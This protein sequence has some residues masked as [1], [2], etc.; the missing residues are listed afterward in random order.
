MRA[1]E[2]EGGAE[3]ALVIRL[4]VQVRVHVNEMF[5]CSL[6]REVSVGRDA[7]GA[8]AWEFGA[9]GKRFVGE[10]EGVPVFELEDVAGWE[11]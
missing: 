9:S 5:A 2:N 10:P 1:P 7:H 3:L 6:D 11:D 8:G 4:I